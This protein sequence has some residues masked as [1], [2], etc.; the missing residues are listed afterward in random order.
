MPVHH[1]RNDKRDTDDVPPLGAQTDGDRAELWR[2]S[3]M[4]TEFVAAIAGMLLLGL[5]LDRWWGTT[6][7]LTIIG[8][9][10]GLI[11]G[12]YNLIRNALQAEKKAAARRKHDQRNP[13]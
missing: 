10:V 5:L 7:A 11:G 4:G 13:D 1:T 3:A 8:A 12:G 6:P 9:V 2:L